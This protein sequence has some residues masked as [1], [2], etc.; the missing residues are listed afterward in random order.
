[1]TFSPLI[2]IHVC[3][4]HECHGLMSVLR[5]LPPNLALALRDANH[6]LS[7]SANAFTIHYSSL[8]QNL[9]F[10][11]YLFFKFL[12]SVSDILGGPYQAVWVVSVLLPL[13][14]LGKFETFLTLPPRSG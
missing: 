14:T 12:R 4:T 13:E 2:V 3:T 6:W 9:S 1:M 10:T 5:P 7:V 11:Q 8:T